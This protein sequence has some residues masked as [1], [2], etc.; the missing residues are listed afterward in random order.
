[1]E[2]L[3]IAKLNTPQLIKYGSYPKV[4]NPV[5]WFL[6]RLS[7]DEIEKLY[8]YDAL[9]SLLFS[10]S[11]HYSAFPGDRLFLVKDMRMRIRVRTQTLNVAFSSFILSL[12]EIQSFAI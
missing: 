10:H 1:M 12:N 8:W 11:L 2:K 7:Y 4:E 3:R 9:L 5:F 6:S